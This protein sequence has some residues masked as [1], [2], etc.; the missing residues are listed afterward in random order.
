MAKKIQ[1]FQELP[2]SQS[3]GQTFGDF[4]FN[5][6]GGSRFGG[7]WFGYGI[8]IHRH[9]FGANL[10][11]TRHIDEPNDVFVLTPDGLRLHFQYHRW[12][13]SWYQVI[14][15]NHPVLERRQKSYGTLLAVLLYY[16]PSALRGLISGI[17][18]ILI[19][20]LMIWAVVSIANLCFDP[21]RRCLLP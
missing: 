6:D 9:R 19:Y 8:P 7:I 5:R 2:A 17:F 11:A 3:G 4:L 20:V 16:M 13:R 14:D 1:Y 21:V 15:V 12:L 18:S 10:V